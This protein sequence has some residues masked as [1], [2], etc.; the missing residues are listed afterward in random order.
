M[1]APF[2]PRGTWYVEEGGS[3]T[4][5]FDRWMK[6]GSSG[7]ASLCEGFHQGYLEGAS[8]YW[9]TRKMRFLRETQNA[10]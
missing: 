2:H 9:G 8:F 5:G 7:G 3:Y 6:E 1:G 4:G 10:L